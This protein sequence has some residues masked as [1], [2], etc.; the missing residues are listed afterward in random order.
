MTTQDRNG[1]SRKVSTLDE[2]TAQRP[3]RSE[4]RQ[5]TRVVGVRVTEAEYAD[6]TA[7][8]EQLRTTVP[9]LFRI[10]WTYLSIAQL[11]HEEG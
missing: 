6:L 5:R 2:L 1:P 10:G 3:A 4:S 8:A 7:A 11:R 9:D